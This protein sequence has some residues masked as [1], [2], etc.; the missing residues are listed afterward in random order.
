MKKICFVGWGGETGFKRGVV[1][2]HGGLMLI[3]H[4]VSQRTR[5]TTA[6]AKTASGTLFTMLIQKSSSSFHEAW[7]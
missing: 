4:Q 5:I 7:K 1:S 2:H 6:I 3:V